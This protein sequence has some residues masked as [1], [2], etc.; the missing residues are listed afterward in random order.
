MRKGSSPEKVFEV[1]LE[2]WETISEGRKGS[3]SR[4][5]GQPVPGTEVDGPGTVGPPDKG[6]YARTPI[7]AWKRE[8]L[9]AYF[10]DQFLEGLELVW[11]Y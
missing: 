10:S 5:Q 9:C 2:G 11:P 3:C 4:G 6:L 1:D 7:C 8:Q